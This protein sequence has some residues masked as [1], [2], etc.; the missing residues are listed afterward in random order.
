VGRR[1]DEAL[2][3]PDDLAS[4]LEQPAHLRRE[5]VCVAVPGGERGAKPPLGEPE[6]VVG[7]R[8]EVPHAE[9]PGGLDGVPGL[10]I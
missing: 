6:P 3:E 9:L 1:H 7:S 8:V 10:G 4:R 5:D 2:V